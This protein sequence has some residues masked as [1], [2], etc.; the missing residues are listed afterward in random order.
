[1]F[2]LLWEAHWFWMIFSVL[3]QITLSCLDI[4]SK[5]LPM[6]LHRFP[7]FLLCLAQNFVLPFGKHIFVLL[8]HSL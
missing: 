3:L 5:I 4:E 8:I 7:N 1:M 2:V 6:L